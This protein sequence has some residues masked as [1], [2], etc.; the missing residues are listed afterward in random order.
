MSVTSVHEKAFLNHILCLPDTDLS[1]DN[2]KN[3]VDVVESS[4]VLGR[5]NSIY[6]WPL[7]DGNTHKVVDTAITVKKNETIF[8]NRLGLV[9]SIAKMFWNESCGHSYLN[10]YDEKQ[11]LRT[12]RHQAVTSLLLISTVK[13]VNLRSVE[14][15]MHLSQVNQAIG[16]ICIR[17]CSNIRIGNDSGDLLFTNFG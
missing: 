6:F 10:G 17:H 4:R 3:L 2:V 9:G 7:I 1:I 13:T 5:K 11:M 12:I 8:R 15:R 14:V 16:T